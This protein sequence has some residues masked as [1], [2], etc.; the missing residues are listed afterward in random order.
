[1]SF[2]KVLG[3]VGIRDLIKAEPLAKPHKEKKPEPP[4]AKSDVASALEMWTR[5]QVV[6]PLGPEDF[7]RVS[8]IVNQDF[9]P[10]EVALASIHNLTLTR[11]VDIHSGY[12]MD[13]GTKIHELVQT[14]LGQLGILI[15]DWRCPECLTIVENTYYPAK[16]V[17]GQDGEWRYV[18]QTIESK[19]YH[20]RG[21]Y[22]GLLM[23]MKRT[24]GVT[25]VD[26]LLEIKTV[27]AQAFNRMTAPKVTAVHQTQ[28]YMHLKG[29]PRGH[30][31]YAPRGKPR[32][33]ALFKGFDVDLDN[34]IV[35][36][37]LEM[38]QK[39]FDA[40]TGAGPVPE[41]TCAPSRRAYCQTLKQCV[42]TAWK[43]P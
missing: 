4:V 37:Y 43:T 9:C 31:L 7:I 12:I 1:M 19:Q 14:Y 2:D 5:V 38:S 22:D 16:C 26:R 17:C 10:R 21:H 36:P 39:I 23:P 28:I 3:V 8:N 20:L 13:V 24:D 15:G 11:K 18:E 30:I 29:V 6:K 25:G 42:D 35:N 40:I 32:D 27:D 34:S 41:A 33:P